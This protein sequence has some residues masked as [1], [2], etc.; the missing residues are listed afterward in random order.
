MP[1]SLSADLNKNFQR[2]HLNCII[3]PA[4]IFAAVRLSFI[5]L[6]IID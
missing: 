6:K 2:Q 3:I 4:P 5:G 1:Y